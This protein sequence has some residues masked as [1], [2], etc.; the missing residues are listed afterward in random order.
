M[1]DSERVIADDDIPL[2]LR[3]HRTTSASTVRLPSRQA[4]RQICWFVPGGVMLTVL[5]AR[6]RSLVPAGIV[7]TAAGLV[8]L[9]ANLVTKRR[10][11]AR[12]AVIDKRSAESFPASDASQY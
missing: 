6:R 2:N 9:A 7:L 1:S 8:A 3:V 10:Q 4:I 12:D 11:V 5:T